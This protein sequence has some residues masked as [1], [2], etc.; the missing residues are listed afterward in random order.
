MLVFVC[1]TVTAGGFIG[2]DLPQGLIAEGMLMR[3]ALIGDLEDLPGVSVLTT[4][5][6]RLPPPP[7]GH[8]T[9][10]EAGDDPHETWDALA[11]QAHCCWPIAPETDGILERFVAT[12]RTHN[13]R[14]I[15]PDLQTLRDC[16]S[17]TRTAEIL[18]AAGV[19]AVPTWRVDE[20][21]EDQA[22]PFVVKPDDGAGALGVLVFSD[23]PQMHLPE[24][25]IIQPYVEGMPASLSLLCQ[26]GRT[27]VLAANRQN[28]GRTA[29]RLSFRGVSVGAL[30]IDDTLRALADRVGAAFPGLHGIVGMDYI[31]T[32]TG[33]VVVEVNPRLTTSYAGLRQALGINPLA[34]VAE[35]IRDG[36]VP[37]LP[38]LPPTV[39][40]EVIA[41]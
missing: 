3:D 13:R 23:R 11:R 18:T 2:Q 26:S 24:Q 21:P 38:R 29:D 33:P 15:A 5:D 22:G 12:L 39:S 31:V 30:P 37:D 17:K 8:S 25:T 41:R 35:L 9:P 19:R 36:A 32:E 14:V 40:V 7:R 1:E 28:I 34:F 16:S 4:H 10:L 27:H 20:I 6:A